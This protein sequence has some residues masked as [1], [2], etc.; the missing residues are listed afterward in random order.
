[1]CLYTPEEIF[2]VF[3]F[4]EQKRDALTTPLPDDGHTPYARVPKKWHWTT[5]RSKIVQ[6]RPTLP[7]VW[8]PS[9]L[10]KYQN[11]MPARV[12][13]GLLNR[14]IQHCWSRSRQLQ[15]VSYGFIGICIHSSRLSL[16]CNDHLQG[17][18]YFCGRETIENHLIHMGTGTN[19][20]HIMTSSIP[21]WF[22]FLGFIFLRKQVCP[23][24]SRKFPPSENFPLYG[25]NA[26][27]FV[28]VLTGLVNYC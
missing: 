26:H 20:Y 5:K 15:S 17:G 24:K 14:R 21:S 11:C 23:R 18:Y 27:F 4:A 25:I 7:F 10:Q 12:K 16:F 1:M 6:Q 9:Q 3:I 22:I 2:T 28:A 8:R 19:S 13:T